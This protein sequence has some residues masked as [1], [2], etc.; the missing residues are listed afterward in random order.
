MV[1]DY[2]DYENWDLADRD[3]STQPRTVTCLSP[4]HDDEMTMDRV[5]GSRYECSEC[6]A[7]VR[8]E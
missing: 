4:E 3:Q 2:E 7:T 5:D 8:V 6:D 1:G